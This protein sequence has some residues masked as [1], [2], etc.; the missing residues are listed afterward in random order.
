MIWCRF[1][2]RVK[3]NHMAFQLRCV[4]LP[5]Q[6]GWLK[7]RLK[8]CF[9]FKFKIKI[10]KNGIALFKTFSDIALKL[11][12][13]VILITKFHDMCPVTFPWQHNGLQVGLLH[14]KNKSRVSLPREVLCA[15]VVRSV[16]VS[17]YGYTVER[18]SNRCRKAKLKQLQSQS[19]VEVIFKFSQPRTEGIC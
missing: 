13:V 7:T 18:S 2:A 16:G 19:K 4:L 14:P 3:V 6:W 5:W 10:T 9:F 15:L 1:F 17:N 11:F 8:K 12:A